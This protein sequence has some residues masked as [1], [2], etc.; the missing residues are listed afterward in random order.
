MK[1]LIIISLLI[2]KLCNGSL[3][4]KEP[5]LY[6]ANLCN[7]DLQIKKTQFWDRVDRER[8]TK[9]CFAFPSDAMP[10]SVR[11]LSL[12]QQLKKMR[13][14]KYFIQYFECQLDTG[15]CVVHD[16]LQQHISTLMKA[17][18]KQDQHLITKN[19][20]AIESL[21][22]QALDITIDLTPA[23]PQTKKTLA[24]QLEWDNENKDGLYA[25]TFPLQWKSIM[26]CLKAKTADDKSLARTNMYSR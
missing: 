3:H 19:I 13:K 2:G 4:E 15:W 14:Y 21:S 18:I 5:Q 20:L 12:S 8:P 9:H 22:E 10:P 26:L 23:N 6:D 16:A 25:R 11:I 1:K 17:N 7:W 24:A